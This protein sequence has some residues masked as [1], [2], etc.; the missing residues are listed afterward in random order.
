MQLK[1]DVDNSLV[2]TGTEEVHAIWKPSTGS[3]RL[4]VMTHSPRALPKH[5]VPDLDLQEEE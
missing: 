4:R 1:L 3:S 5:C 2:K